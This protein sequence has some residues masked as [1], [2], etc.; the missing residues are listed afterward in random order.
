M[1]QAQVT[2]TIK[3][4]EEQPAIYTTGFNRMAV[5]PQRVRR[6]INIACVLRG[7]SNTN[8]MKIFLE[9]LTEQEYINWLKNA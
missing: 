4:L 9:S 8:S 3:L 1:N 2:K 7:E 6:D 5:L